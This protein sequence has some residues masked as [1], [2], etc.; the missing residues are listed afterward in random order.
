MNSNSN[1]SERTSA[2]L[3]FGT[4]AIALFILYWLTH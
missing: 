2:L 3:V 1:T 4:L